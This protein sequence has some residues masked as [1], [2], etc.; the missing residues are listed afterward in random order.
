MFQS[1]FIKHDSS[2]SNSIIPATMDNKPKK[3]NMKKNLRRSLMIAIAFAIA[4]LFLV[5]KGLSQTVVVNPTSPFTVPAGVTSIKVEVWGA[6][7]GGGGGTGA[8]GF[9]GRGGGGGGG[10]YN[11]ATFTT[12]PGHTFTITIGAGGTAGATAAGGNGGS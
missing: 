12:V 2:L 9:F 6:G 5:N 8:A 3:I 4:N 10:A 7:G 11:V 1:L